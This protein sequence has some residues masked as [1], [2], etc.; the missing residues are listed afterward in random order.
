MVLVVEF[1]LAGRRFIAINAPN[2][3]FSE[4]VSFQIHCADQ[5]EMDRLWAALS[6]GGSE[7]ACG[8]LTDRWGLS[9]QV[10]PI[11]MYELLNDADPDRS[12]RTMEAM[13]TLVKL[14]VAELERAAN[15]AS[16]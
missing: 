11:R 4:A 1:T 13:M 6:D 14:D 8:W 9:W 10:T 12:R 5:A 3:P 2:R 15:G 7:V 16:A